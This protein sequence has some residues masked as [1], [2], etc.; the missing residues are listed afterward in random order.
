MRQLYD[1]IYKFDTK[2]KVRVWRMEQENGRHRTIAGIKDGNLVTSGWTQCEHTNVGQSNHRDPVEQ[3]SFEIAAA[4]KKKL[5]REYHE[6]IEGAKGGA[7]FFKPMLAEKYDAK[8]FTSGFAQPKL[9]GI[10]CIIKADGMWSR[11]GRPIK[12]APHIFE[13][14]VSLFQQIPDL[15]LDGEIYNHDLKDDFNTIVSIVK[16]QTPN[17][18]ELEK[19]RLLAQYHSYDLPSHTGPFRERTLMLGKLLQGYAPMI[20]RVQTQSVDTVE[21]YDKWH[22]EWL[23]ARYEGSMW[24]DDKPY[25]Q[26]RSKTLRKRKEFIDEEFEVVRIEEG[27]GNWAGAAKNV[28]C[29]FPDGREF[30]AGIAGTY[31]RGVELLHEKH[32]VVTIKYF[33]LTPDGIPRF[34][35]ATKFHGDKREL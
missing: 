2:G 10:R 18:D 32:K 15:V 8:K 34:G 3:A 7:H 29:R 21:V 20:Q 11:E 14:L 27:L 31:E 35:V 4:Y 24:R 12:G 16:N 17:T 33:A 22:L 25:E 28:I 26:K 6:T 30:G 13:A 5:T 19:S 23:E 1:P 9:D